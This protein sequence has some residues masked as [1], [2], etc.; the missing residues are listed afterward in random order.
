[1]DG[2]WIAI[3][4]LVSAFV[5]GALQAYATTRF[6]KSKFE[7]EAKWQLYSSYFITLGELSFTGRSEQRHID[8]LARMANIRGQIGIQGS[9]EVIEA[10]GRVFRHP[11]LLSNEAQA[12]MAVALRA[13]R[14]DLGKSEG[15]LSDEAMTQLM[16][17]SRDYE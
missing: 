7:R 4:G 5:G 3:I 6:E 11:D 8:A 17:G 16:F 10:V 15:R 9:P 14:R 12:A 1:M 2:I 13:M